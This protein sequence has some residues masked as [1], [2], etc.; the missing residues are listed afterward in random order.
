MEEIKVDLVLEIHSFDNNI[1]GSTSLGYLTTIEGV[2]TSLNVSYDKSSDIRA[3]CTL[4]MIV[5]DDKWLMESGSNIWFDKGFKIYLKYRYLNYDYHYYDWNG[6][7]GLWNNNGHLP[8]DPSIINLGYFLP[9]ENTYTYDET[10]KSLSISG[11]DILSLYMTE[12][13]G[14]LRNIHETKNDY[15]N[16]MGLT[17]E[18]SDKHLAWGNYGQNIVNYYGSHIYWGEYGVPEKW[19]EAV[20]EFFNNDEPGQ[21]NDESTIREGNNYTTY[22][23]IYDI[24][25]NYSPP[26]VPHSIYV[27]LYNDMLA[28]PYDLEFNADVSMFDVLKKIVDLY[29]HQGIYY[30]VNQRLNL[31]QYPVYW[32]D[33]YT[34]YL[35]R[36]LANLVINE[37]PALSKA[38]VYNEVI[39]FGR[40]D[41]CSAIYQVRANLY[42]NYDNLYFPLQNRDEVCPVCGRPLDNLS[43]NNPLSIDNIGFRKQVRHNDNLVTDDECLTEAKFYALSQNQYSEPISLRVADRYLSM[44]HSDNLGIGERI[45]YTSIK[46]GKTNV[47]ILQKLSYSMSATSGSEW[48]MELTPFRPIDDET[49]PR[50]AKPT[51]SATVDENG[52]VTLSATSANLDASLYKFY[53]ISGQYEYWTSMYSED[54]LGE[55]CTYNSDRTAKFLTY[56]LPHNGVYYFKASAYNRNRAP[57]AYSDVIKVEFYGYENPMLLLDESEVTIADETAILV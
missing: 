26:I 44:F 55:S 22:D 37:T 34:N 15:F 21:Y 1:Y 24:F 28:L 43:G 20:T 50:L 14:H 30:D 29:S 38:N 49:E 35:G 42:C 18:G 23:L 52:M 31:V 10:T 11:K 6:K 48:N 17:L 19:R 8:S 2:C 46:T 36:E 54:F 12:Y 41:T 25:L 33:G 9:L 57:S 13:G 4:E 51:L 53:S 39:M 16:Y 3:T 40:Q 47:Y 5:A 32:R 45:E 7:R 56:K 27:K